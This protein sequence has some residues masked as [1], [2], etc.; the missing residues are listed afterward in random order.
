MCSATARVDVVGTNVAIE[1]ATIGFVKTVPSTT[2]PSVKI[3]TAEEIENKNHTCSRKTCLDGSY[4][5]WST[6]FKFSNGPNA[7]SSAESSEAPLTSDEQLVVDAIVKASPGDIWMFE[8]SDLSCMEIRTCF[9]AALPL[10]V[11]RKEHIVFVCNDL[12]RRDEL[13]GQVQALVAASSGQQITFQSDAFEERTQ[14]N[15]RITIAV[16]NSSDLHHV[17]REI[18]DINTV[19]FVDPVMNPYLLK[20][21]HPHL[22]I[23]QKKKI[24]MHSPSTYPT[25]QKYFGKPS[26]VVEESIVDM[27]LSSAVGS[28]VMTITHEHRTNQILHSVCIDELGMPKDVVNCISKWIVN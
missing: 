9:R 17:F 12:K 27:V 8:H 14:N 15:A 10:L 13:V 3:A 21:L 1:T 2:A 26:V 23:R 28:K 6:T 19:V 11:Q 7:M 20:A 25:F 22:A 18:E 5:S 4:R 16:C 24:F